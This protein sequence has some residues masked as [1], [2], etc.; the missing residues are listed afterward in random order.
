MN[1]EE[2]LALRQEAKIRTL[3]M[4]KKFKLAKDISK[5]FQNN[6]KCLNIGIFREDY[7]MIEVVTLMK[8]TY[9]EIMSIT[10]IENGEIFTIDD[11]VAYRTKGSIPAVNLYY[12][13]KEKTE[14]LIKMLKYERY[15]YRKLI[16]KINHHIDKVGRRLADNYFN[17]RNSFR[18][19]KGLELLSNKSRASYILCDSNLKF[20]FK[21]IGDEVDIHKGYDK[22]Q[23]KF[24]MKEIRK[25][26]RIFFMEEF[27]KKNNIKFYGPPK[28]SNNHYLTAY[29]EFKPNEIF[30]EFVSRI[31]NI[32]INIIPDM[33]TKKYL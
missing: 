12:E 26:I 28:F 15:Q 8:E 5:V 21:E 33:Y 17:Q 16:N 13:F 10:N 29:N 9:Y 6:T 11:Y 25:Q 30:A 20:E 3:I 22:L 27:Y 32:F 2:K 7:L 1:D 31:E 23:K 14:T 24:L 19:R 4:D 18:K